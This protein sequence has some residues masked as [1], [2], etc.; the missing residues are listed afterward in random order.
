MPSESPPRKS[1]YK[2]AVTFLSLLVI[3]T[4]YVII[5]NVIGDKEKD[6]CNEK[7]HNV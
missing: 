2:I 5:K 4:K 7:T 3:R 1:L 6:V